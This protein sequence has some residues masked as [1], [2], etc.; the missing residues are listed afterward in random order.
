MIKSA[1]AILPILPKNRVGCPME[2]TFG[3]IEGS[4]KV[5]GPNKMYAK[6]STSIYPQQHRS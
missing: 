5:F 3:V 1:E 2:G 6:V 4:L